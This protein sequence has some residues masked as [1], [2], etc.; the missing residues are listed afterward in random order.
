MKKYFI[1][2]AFCLPFL[3][4][5]QEEQFQIQSPSEQLSVAV[6]ISKTNA[7]LRLQHE[8]QPLMDVQTLQF[9]FK[10]A[11][12]MGDYRVVHSEHSSTDRTWQ[13]L[14][15][16][17]K[18]VPD[19]Y[20]ELRLTLQSAQNAKEFY[21]TIR[22]YDE[23]LAFQYAFEKTD[24]W[25]TTLTK[26]QTAFLFPKDYTTWA[27]RTAQGLYAP[28]KLSAMDISA[29]RPQVVQCGDRFVA[30]GEAAL[31]DYA[32]MKL[33]KSS[34]G[35]GLEA[36]LS[37]EV[38][39]DKARYTSPWRYVLVGENISDLAQKS[40]LLENLN[41]PCAIENTA[42]IKPGKVLREVTL[43]TAG[44]E[45]CVDFAVKNGLSYVEF[46]AGWYGHEY[47]DASDATTITIDPKR[48]KGPLDLHHII[49]YAKD[50]GIGILLY[51]NIRALTKQLDEI[52]PLYQR[53]GVKG[54]KYGFVN[55]GSQE[56]TS[57]LHHAV[58][59]A[60]KYEL[61]VDIHDEYRPT[62]YSRTYPNLMTQEGIRGDEET[63]SVQQS[64]FTLY[65]RMLCG[66]GD[67]TNC[68]YAERVG[69]E[70]MG[71]KAAQLAKLVA[72]YSPW[73]FVYWYDRP[74][75]IT[76]FKAGIGSNISLLRQETGTDFIASVPTVWDDSRF[77]QG[78]MGEYAV[79]ARRSGSEWFVGVLNA[80]TKRSH[81]FPTD[82]LE[83]GKTYTVVQY[84]QTAKDLKKNKVRTRT[85]TI[86]KGKN[87]TCE[88]EANS[89]CAYTIKTVK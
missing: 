32:R 47:D 74:A 5:A 87:I 55:V 18:Q 1:L 20:N 46:D 60:A 35:I 19:T 22:L 26:E 21:C 43:T 11:M 88:L 80:N 34:T 17:R 28:T 50:R 25:N 23:G 76:D 86:E 72:L 77:V 75:N 33:K 49:S 39:L 36:D 8:K 62:G 66:A 48:S 58:R 83:Q 63:P 69:S 54:V 64:I 6:S 57:W 52:L 84:F 16:E 53:W 68:F 81:T 4:Q 13:P 38:L 7:S 78:E 73:Q 15:G 12:A 51:V 41:A 44:A 89:G 71:G 65:N 37:S 2:L 61:M 70:K 45:A 85:F 56:A 40:Y 3:A 30:I 27:T 67:N 42:W 31:V 14:Y 29:D 9:A 24:F 59:K 82:F 79:V 10:E